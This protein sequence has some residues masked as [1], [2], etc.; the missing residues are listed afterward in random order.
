MR[1]VRWFI[2]EFQW[3]YSNTEV[4]VIFSRRVLT[5]NPVSFTKPFWMPQEMFCSF[6]LCSKSLIEKLLFQQGTEYKI[7]GIEPVSLIKVATLICEFETL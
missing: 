7:S 6:V 4:T 3:I 1:C 5:L 2:V